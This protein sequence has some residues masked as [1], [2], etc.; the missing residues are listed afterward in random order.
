MPGRAPSELPRHGLLRPGPGHDY[1][2]GRRLH[3]A[4][5]RLAGVP[6]TGPRSTAARSTTSTRAATGR[7]SCSSTASAARW[8]NW[9]L[10]IPELRARRTGCIAPDLPGFGE[11]EM[12]REEISIRATRRWSTRCCD[13]ARRSSGGGGRQLDGR[14]R[15]RR[16]GD[17]ATRSG[18]SGWCS[19]RR[20]ASSAELPARASRCC[21]LARLSA[22]A[23]HAGARRSADRRHRYA[24]PR[25]ARGAAARSSRYPRELA[26][27]A[28]YE[29]VAAA[30]HARLPRPR[31]TR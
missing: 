3:V 19:S 12:P 17:R 24:A 30:R 10:N 28:A 1:A 13:R 25:C 22:G 14:L 31:W 7:R 2:D 23:A 5:R 27:P 21:A 6:S 18:W 16:A 9:L 26:G 29:L 8:Q 15:R 11:S 20:P 4:R